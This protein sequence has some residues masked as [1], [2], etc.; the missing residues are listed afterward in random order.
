MSKKRYLM[1][2]L[3]C[4]IALVLVAW[5]LQVQYRPFWSTSE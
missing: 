5:G 4:T 1:V 2:M 3:C